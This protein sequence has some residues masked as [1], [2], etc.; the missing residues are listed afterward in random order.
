MFDDIALGPFLEDPARKNTI[1]FV[2]ALILHRQLHE[3]AGLGRVLPRRGLLAGAQP[4][5]RTADA[6]RFAGLHLQLAHQPVA[7]V[8]QA[9][10]RDALGHRGCALDAADFLRHVR[11]ARGV[12]GVRLLAAASGA[13]AAG[14]RGGRQQRGQDQGQRARHPAAHSAP[15]RQAS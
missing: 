12:G 7:L 5:D 9:Q 10:H 3:G 14:E 4:H 11:G 1:P 15:G 6:R 2:V 13:I 8:K